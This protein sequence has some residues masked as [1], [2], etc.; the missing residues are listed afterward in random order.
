MKTTIH[1]TVYFSTMGMEFLQIQ[2]NVYGSGQLLILDL[3][4]VDEDDDLI[5]ITV[6]QQKGVNKLYL[7]DGKGNFTDSNQI[8][9]SNPDNNESKAVQF[10]DIDN[11]GD[12]D[13]VIGDWNLGLKIFLNDNYGHF[14]EYGVSLGSGKVGDVVLA[15]IDHDGD[16]DI[17]E[18]NKEGNCNKIYF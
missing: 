14:N 18:S 12:L 4:D 16:L 13:L 2:D 17:V 1:L 6:S 15:D 10:G 9:D 5:L 11:D 3:G 7:N 8:L